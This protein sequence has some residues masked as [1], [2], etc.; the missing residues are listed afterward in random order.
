MQCPNIQEQTRNWP[1][2]PLTA[3]PLHAQL[4][5]TG[6]RTGTPPTPPPAP[7]PTP[8]PPTPLH[9]KSRKTPIAPGGEG[10]CGARREASGGEGGCGARREASG[11]EGGCGARGRRQ[12]LLFGRDAPSCPDKTRGNCTI[13]GAT[14]RRH[15][16]SGLLMVQNP[17]LRLWVKVAAVRGA[18]P[19]GVK[20]AAVRGAR[21]VGGEGGCGARG[22]RQGLAGLRD[23][24]LR[25]ALACGDLAGGPPP[26]GARRFG[27]RASRRVEG[28]RREIAR[29]FGGRASR[30]VEGGR[31]EAA[32]KVGGGVLRGG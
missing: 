10:G 29:R 24:P 4:G 30:R 16:D 14:R 13:R 26:P 22:R 27:G 5:P 17:P 8:T 20:V 2:E 12:G 9:A 28:G 21:P 1:T 3:A 19:V 25:A 6:G 32:R 31:R 11:G 23:R 15:A 7:R 18:R